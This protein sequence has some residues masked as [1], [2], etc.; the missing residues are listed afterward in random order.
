ME[1]KQAPTKPTTGRLK[2]AVLASVIVIAGFLYSQYG[3]AL[4]LDQL[5]AKE[6][7]LRAYQDANALAGALLAFLVYVTVTGLSLPGAAVLTLCL[8]WLLGFGKGLLVVSFASTA[9]ATLAFL[10]SRF[11]LRESVMNRFG[12][13]LKTVN[14]AL[15]REGPFYLFSLRLI[16]VIPFF[17]I[18]LIMGLTP[19]RTTTFWW[20]SQLG[21]L[22]AT[23]VYVYAGS[24]FPSLGELAEKGITGILRPELLIAFAILGLFPLVVKKVFKRAKPQT[25]AS[26]S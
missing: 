15:E 6:D 23:A 12:D 9:G 4:S 21:M 18:N 11:L 17:V 19:I 10:F 8:G 5:A 26:Q 22:P 7:Q 14:A 3:H 1:P 20:V 13:R 24:T 16:P 25:V 2:M